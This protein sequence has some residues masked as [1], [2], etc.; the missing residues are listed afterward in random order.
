[1]RHDLT[2]WQAQCLQ[3]MM[4]MLCNAM[5]D[6]S[7]VIFALPGSDGAQ[8]QG[9]PQEHEG[10]HGRGGAAQDVPGGGAARRGSLRWPGTA[11]TRCHQQLS[12]IHI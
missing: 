6:L 1:M 2:G 3:M 5:T 8:G 7:N 12:L 10:D 9:L 4:M 11:P